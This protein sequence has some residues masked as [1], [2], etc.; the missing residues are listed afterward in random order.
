MVTDI[1]VETVAKLTL[2]EQ[3]LKVVI[4]AKYLGITVSWNGFSKN[5]NRE[6]EVKCRRACAATTSQPFFDVM[7]PLKTIKS[8]YRTNVRSII[9]YGTMQTKNI[10]T[11]VDLDHKILQMYYKRLLHSKPYLCPKLLERLCIRI[12]MPSLMMDIERNSRTW[13]VKLGRIARSHLVKTVRLQSWDALEAIE[14]LPPEI[15]V[16]RYFTR[17]PFNPDIW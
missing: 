2:A 17:G 16:R 4:E 9:L 3:P 6:Q 1:P 5:S 10:D 7:L 12:R 11:L 14:I 13:T 8:L 15:P